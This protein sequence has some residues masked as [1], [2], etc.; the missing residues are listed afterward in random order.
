M[1]NYKIKYL[2]KIMNNKNFLAFDKFGLLIESLYNHNSLVMV[3]LKT[4]AVYYDNDQ[5]GVLI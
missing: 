3:D 4:G 5:I 2:N 1:A